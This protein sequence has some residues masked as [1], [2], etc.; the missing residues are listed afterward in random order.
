MID[1]KAF[2]Y[3]YKKTTS[4]EEADL[5]FLPFGLGGTCLEL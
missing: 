4:L 5:Q 3:E 1:T 2:C